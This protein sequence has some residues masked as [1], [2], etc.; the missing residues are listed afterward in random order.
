M[1]GFAA[2]LIIR[3]VNA[4]HYGLLHAMISLC[5]GG[6]P[7]QSGAESFAVLSHVLGIDPASLSA[8]YMEMSSGKNRRENPCI[9]LTTDGWLKCRDAALK[10]M[11]R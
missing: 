6:K 1:R 4:D 9:T 7:P 5:G 2:T 11:R 10:Q 3:V 8:L